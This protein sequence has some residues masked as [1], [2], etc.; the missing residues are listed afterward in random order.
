M[1]I[2]WPDTRASALQLLGEAAVTAAVAL[3]TVLVIF[4]KSREDSALPKSAAK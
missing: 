4:R 2:K 3:F 1:E